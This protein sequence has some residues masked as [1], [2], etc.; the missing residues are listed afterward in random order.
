MAEQVTGIVGAEVRQMSRLRGGAL[1]S[2]Y[3]VKLA[4]G[5]TL[6]AKVAR[7]AG[8]EARMLASMRDSGARVPR[9]LGHTDTLLVMEDLGSG[10]PLEDGDGAGWRA[11]AETLRALHAARGPRYGWEEDHA[12]GKVSIAN[13]PAASWLEFWAE[14]RLIG[15]SVGL[16]AELQRRLEKLARR[17]SDHLPAAPPPALLHGDLWAGNVLLDRSRRPALIDP[18]C[19]FGDRYVDLAMLSFFARPPAEFEIGRAHV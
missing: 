14:H 8:R 12:F 1:S 13:A 17:L 16:T 5:E 4:D 19:Y 3:R 7:G 18:A 2:V 15:P 6:V 10:R 9:P 11:L